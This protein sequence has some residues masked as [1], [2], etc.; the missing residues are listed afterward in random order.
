MDILRP[1]EDA[2][3]ELSLVGDSETGEGSTEV[4]RLDKRDKRGIG[5]Y[6]DVDVKGRELAA[7][8]IEGEQ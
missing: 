7:D 6:V 1:D 5:M 3:I 2:G 4:P 8:E